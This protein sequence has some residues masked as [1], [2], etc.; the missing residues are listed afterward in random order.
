MD[1]NEIYRKLLIKKYLDMVKDTI[2]LI[3][4]EKHIAETR[5]LCIKEGI[6]SVECEQI[7]ED[8]RSDHK[9]HV[10]EIEQKM[11]ECVIDQGSNYL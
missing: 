11:K 5:E 6:W 1:K 3:D 7:Y 2:E 4:P 8:L 9:R 10:D